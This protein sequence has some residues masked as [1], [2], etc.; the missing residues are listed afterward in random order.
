MTRNLRPIAVRMTLSLLGVIG[1]ACSAP[2]SDAGAKADTAQNAAVETSAAPPALVD[3]T[4][5]VDL[6]TLGTA[7]PPAESDSVPRVVV[8]PEKVPVVRSIPEAPAALAEAV[9]REDGISRFCYQEF[10]QKVD[11]R[12][13]GGV[14]LVLTVEGSA[15]TAARVAA[16]SWSSGAGREVNRCLAEK[17]PRAL[18]LLD[19]VP[20]GRY[21]VQLRFRAS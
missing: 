11:P 20:P 18:R 9:E 3:D 21:V 2:A 6:S 12:L 10:G 4:A 5:A 15:V 19:P 17:Y 16:D 13:R 14:A 7:L 1:A 8:D